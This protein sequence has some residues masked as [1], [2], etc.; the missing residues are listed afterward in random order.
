REVPVES[1]SQARK[2][3]AALPHFSS[4]EHCTP[5]SAFG[6]EMTATALLYGIFVRPAGKSNTRFRSST[7]RQ[8]AAHD[9]RLRRRDFGCYATGAAVEFVVS[10]TSWKASEVS[11]EYQTTCLALVNRRRKSSQ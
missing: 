11:F 6:L 8:K 9:A 7:V 10:G 5:A 2:R 3:D 1:D 4:A